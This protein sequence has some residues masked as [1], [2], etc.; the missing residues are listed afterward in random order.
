M[1]SRLQAKMGAG[2]RV[3]LFLSGTTLEQMPEHHAETF[4]AIHDL[5]RSGC[6][7]LLAGPYYNSLPA[8]RVEFSEQIQLHS[9]LVRKLFGVM[10]RSL[11]EREGLVRKTLPSAQLWTERGVRE[12]IAECE[13]A[14]VDAEVLVLTIDPKDIFIAAGEPSE[15]MLLFERFVTALKDE[16]GWGFSDPRCIVSEV[17][18]L[19]ETLTHLLRQDGGRYLENSMQRK[20]FEMLYSAQSAASIPVETWR[21]LQDREYLLQMRIGGGGSRNVDHQRGE[22]ASPYDTFI[23]FMNILR[24]AATS[25]SETNNQ[26]SGF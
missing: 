7:E 1:V 10:P 25:V 6:I 14:A 8:Q 3:A 16:L 24:G 2:F 26:A 23:V 20:A 19:G 11:C 9:D 5:V 15:E 12:L 21:R 13:S 18:D 17:G 4:R 22:L